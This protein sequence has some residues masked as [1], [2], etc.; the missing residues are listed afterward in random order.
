MALAAKRG[1]I[2][3]N[4]LRGPARQMYE[5]MT[6]EQLAEYARRPDGR[7]ILSEALQELR[8]SD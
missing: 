8:D 5:T 1:K 7:S 4:K 2:S 6:E 3:P